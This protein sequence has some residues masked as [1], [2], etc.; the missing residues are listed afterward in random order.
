MLLDTAKDCT[1]FVMVDDAFSIYREEL[2]S[3]CTHI[4]FGRN[5][6]AN[7]YKSSTIIDI[8]IKPILTGPI[9]H[10]RCVRVGPRTSIKLHAHVHD[11]RE[12]EVIK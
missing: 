8:N 10:S 3:Y 1:M 9:L 6:V 11:K 5:R 12:D 2:V 7:W 4:Y